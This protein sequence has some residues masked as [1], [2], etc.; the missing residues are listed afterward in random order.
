[1]VEQVEQILNWQG[2]FSHFLG[3]FVGLGF[4]SV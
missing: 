2:K 1:M 4:K 3:D